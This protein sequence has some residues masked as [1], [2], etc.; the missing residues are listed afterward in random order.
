MGDGF[1][2]SFEHVWS[3]IDLP[4]F[5]HQNTRDS[6]R[7]SKIKMIDSIIEGPPALGD[8]IDARSSIMTNS[9]PLSETDDEILKS[10]KIARLNAT[11]VGEEK[12]KQLGVEA[13]TSVTSSSGL[14]PM[15]REAASDEGIDYSME[16]SSASKPITAVFNDDIRAQSSSHVPMVAEHVVALSYRRSCIGIGPKVAVCSARYN[17]DVPCPSCWIDACGKCAHR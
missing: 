3:V 11:C 13:K 5:D 14:M 9:L 10:I 16:A 4:L 7:F 12:E 6:L 2:Y 17:V 15:K 1:Q 8:P